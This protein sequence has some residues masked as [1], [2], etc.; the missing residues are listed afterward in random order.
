MAAIKEE[1]DIL[2]LIVTLVHTDAISKNA[3]VLPSGIILKV[4]RNSEGSPVP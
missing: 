4:T 1:F 2:H 3:T